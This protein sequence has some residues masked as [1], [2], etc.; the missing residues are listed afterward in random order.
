TPS[1][2]KMRR[3]SPFG[4]CCRNSNI[5]NYPK[6]CLELPRRSLRFVCSEENKHILHDKFVNQT[7]TL[8]NACA[9]PIRVYA[10][11]GLTNKKG[12]VMKYTYQLQQGYIRTRNRIK[13]SVSGASLLLLGAG[14][15]V[16]APFAVFAYGGTE[17]SPNACGGKVVL[18]VTYTLLNDTDS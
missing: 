12:G 18:N 17:T 4:I 13:A 2:A 9:R 16:A 10:N 14:I 15:A 1:R 11:G 5:K 3:I 7:I 8:V 6:E